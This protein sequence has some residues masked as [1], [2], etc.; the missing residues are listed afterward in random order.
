MEL[1]WVEEISSRYQELEV[2]LHIPTS[3]F[4]QE[5]EGSTSD[6]G[7]LFPGLEQ[8]VTWRGSLRRR[9][10]LE[11]ECAKGGWTRLLSG[12]TL[13]PSTAAL[14]AEWELLK[15]SRSS[16]SKSGSRSPA[17]VPDMPAAERRKGGEFYTPACVVRLLV[18]ML[19]PYKGRVYDPCCGSGGMFVQSE[20]FIRAHGGGSATSCPSV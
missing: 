13:E 15:R 5:S 18:E 10:Y 6:S 19:E 9:S 16:V 1:A 4:A 3:V 14:G 11:R 8:S 7:K 17:I 12:L 20:E 2:W